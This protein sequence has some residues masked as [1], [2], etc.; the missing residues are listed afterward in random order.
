MGSAVKTGRIIL[1]SFFVSCC[2]LGM[3]DRSFSRGYAEGELLIRFKPGVPRVSR[4]AFHRQHGLR[5]IRKFANAGIHH[6]RIMEGM[7]T[8]E[9]LKRFK[10][11]KDIAYVVPNHKRSLFA[12]VPNDPCWMQQWG[13][14]KIRA[15]DAWAVTYG[16]NAVRVAVLDARVAWEHPDLATNV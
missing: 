12:V 10:K 5:P 3:A 4:E 15:P 7:K 11:L 14:E 16:D 1:L 9:A 2:L 13:M 6:V 8:D